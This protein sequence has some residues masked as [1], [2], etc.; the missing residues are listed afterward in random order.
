[1]N[2]TLNLKIINKY[3]ESVLQMV[4]LSY[5][6]LSSREILD[7]I[8]YSIIKRM[9]NHDV[10]LENNYKNKEINSTLID[11]TEFI[12]EQEPIITANGVLYKK[13]SEAIN[14]IANL[15]QRFL[16]QRKIYKKEMFKNSKGS[17]QF[18]KYNLL[19]L[20]SKIDANAQL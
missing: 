3:K 15:M 2:N 5:P 6:E 1:M 20:L 14:P 19:Q 12:L 18:E 13:K 17:E 9:K 8:D 11:I 4:H 7:A 10:I 16:S